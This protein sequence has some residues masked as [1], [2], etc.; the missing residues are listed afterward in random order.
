MKSLT[1][2]IF[3]DYELGRVLG[4]KGTES[5]MA[6]FN[7]KEEDT[8]YTFIQ[9]LEG[10][11]S[12]KAQ[13]MSV[14][15]VAIVSFENP[16]P[17]LGETILMLNAIGVKKGIA[18]ATPG[19][20]VKRI[21]EMTRGTS[22]ESFTV[23]DRD[24]HHI[25]DTLSRIEHEPDN[26]SPSSV[27]VDHS[28]SVRGVGEIVLGFVKSGIV[29]KHQKLWLYPQKKEILVRSIQMHDK[30]FDEAP[31]GS[32]VGLAIKGATVEE[33]RRGAII[34]EPE[35]YRVSESVKISFDANVFYEGGITAGKFHA[36][37]GMQYF[38]AEVTDISGSTITLKADRKIAY[39]KNERFILMDLNAQKVHFMGSGT[40]SE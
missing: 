22:L 33:M 3:N 10:K 37:V 5:D 35:S 32:R 2:G 28:F 25:F 31:S 23:R 30:D 11:L 29:K 26:E 12:A 18:I 20:D 40:P 36:V 1:I 19:T 24:Q 13:I 7:R 15:D 34:A 17:E 16:G 27:A 21:V 39:R 6:F 38:P 8:A 4:K 9:P 14:I